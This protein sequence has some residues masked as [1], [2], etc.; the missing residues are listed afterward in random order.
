MSNNER[1]C[2]LNRMKLHCREVREACSFLLLFFNVPVV[3]DNIYLTSHTNLPT[4][5]ETRCY[6]GG[7][8]GSFSFSS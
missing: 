1:F 6:S 3:G 7:Q 4:E 5:K 2:Y 8:G